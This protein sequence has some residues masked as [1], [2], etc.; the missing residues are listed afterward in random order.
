MHPGGHLLSAPASRNEASLVIACTHPSPEFTQ[1]RLAALLAQPIDWSDVFRLAVAHG[2]SPLLS[3][4]LLRFGAN[5]VPGELNAALA[6]HVEDNRQR[7]LALL[8]ALNELL[9]RLESRGIRAVPF[10]GQTLGA[11]TGD[12]FTMRRA[13]DL[14]ILVRRSELP[15]VWT[16]LEQLGFREV[17]EHELG[18]PMSAV[19]HA[20]HLDYQCEY[21]FVRQHDGV[22]VE[23]HWA[24]APPTLAIDLP[25]ERFLADARTLPLGKH[26]VPSLSLPHMLLVA[27][28]HA[29]K[30]EWTR[31][32]WIADVAG[33]VERHAAL[34]AGAVLA[35]AQRHG[36][37][38]MVLLG[39]ALARRVYSVPLPQAAMQR[40]SSDGVAARLAEH[41][42]ATLLSVSRDTPSLTQVSRMRLLM[43]ERTRDKIG[44]VARTAVTPTEKHYRLLALP[45]SL[46]SLYLPIKLLHDYAALPVWTVAKRTRRWAARHAWGATPRPSGNEVLVVDWLPH[47]SEGAGSPRLNRMLR[48]LA[49]A[50]Y[51]I[52]LHPVQPCVEADDVLYADIPRSVEVVRGHGID[53]V[54]AFLSR[55]ADRFG[56]IVVGRPP[57]MAYLRPVF[58]RLS[59]RLRHTRI[60]YDSEALFALRTIAQRAA[61]GDPVSADREALLVADEV[62]LA[63]G[64]DAVLAVSRQEQRIFEEHD[65]RNVLL[66]GYPIE[67]A[68]TPRTFAEREGLL[69]VGRVAEDGWPNTDSLVWYREHVV[70]RLA[71]RG[72]YPTLIVAGKTG[73]RALAGDAGGNMRFV[74]TVDDLAPLFDAA[75]VFIAPT[76]FAAGIPVKLYEAAAHGVPIVATRLLADQLGWEPGEDLLACDVGDA[77]AFADHIVTL[78]TQPDVWSRLRDN[79][80][81]R[82]ADDCAPQAILARLRQAIHG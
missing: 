80:L 31:L 44:Y 4:R 64:V 65:I 38:R 77:D 20:G 79:A 3:Q 6:E 57:N 81:R 33:L 14:D 1:A 75:R 30:H 41:I 45:G 42:A 71:A 22:V 82:V 29:S 68:L 34:D 13:G 67:P 36:V 11:A 51:G 58:A 52:T 21:A 72:H 43:R 74:G 48:L 39:L 66:V 37:E 26:T 7:N 19:E 12:D 25:H 2:V 5:A 16:V 24:L 55:E 32:Q 28:V 10:K 53:H 56:A 23:P 61:L 18:R 9:V 50:G 70:P 60:V 35:L 59:D 63:A 49:D 17:T 69:F 15:A 62:A 76:R 54:D 73:A 47:V 40:L 27:C 78:C 8:D 46:R